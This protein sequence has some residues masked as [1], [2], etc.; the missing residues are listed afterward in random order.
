MPIRTQLA[1]PL[2]DFMNGVDFLR[3]KTDKRQVVLSYVTAGNFI[4]AYAGNYVY[5]GHAN[6]PDEEEKEKIV[7][8][9]FKGE[10]SKEEGRNFINKERVNYIYY[11]PQEKELGGIDKLETKYPFLQDVYNN[12]QVVIYKITK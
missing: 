2:K 1:Y 12:P 6:T 7:E 5:I 10:M 8:R 3:D 11:G 4:P 9:F